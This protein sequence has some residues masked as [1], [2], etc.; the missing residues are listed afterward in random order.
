MSIT[1]GYAGPQQKKGGGA[2]VLKGG[3]GS[4]G[5]ATAR[6][7]TPHNAPDQVCTTAVRRVVV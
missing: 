2:V 3:A 6:Y 7:S 1:Q 5:G 4:Q